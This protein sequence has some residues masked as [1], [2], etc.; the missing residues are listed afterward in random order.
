MNGIANRILNVKFL[1]KKL[2]FTPIYSCRY[3]SVDL[4]FHMTQLET[5]HLKKW[6]I[7]TKGKA[8]SSKLKHL[9]KP[10]GGFL[11]A[12]HLQLVMQYYQF[13]HSFINLQYLKYIYVVTTT[14]DL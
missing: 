12:L 2:K 5:L 6:L 7:C 10:L 3:V 11:D 4:K 14:P 1:Q 8:I 9:Y 13:I